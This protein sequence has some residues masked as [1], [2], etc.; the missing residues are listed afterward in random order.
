MRI[1]INTKDITLTPALEAYI[2]E[3]FT[4]HIRKFV[5]AKNDPDLPLLAIDIGR[6]TRH[7]KKGNIFYAEANLQMGKILLRAVAESEDIHSACDLMRDELEREIK[8]F[9]EKRKTLQKKGARA[10]KE[11]MRNMEE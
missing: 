6:S 8:K 3:K 7:H 2:E 5:E 11:E 9:S 4:S 1:S 10:A